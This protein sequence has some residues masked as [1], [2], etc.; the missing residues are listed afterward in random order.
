VK[1]LGK[2]VR[3]QA[4]IQ[5]IE[6]NTA[7]LWFDGLDPRKINFGLAMYGRGYTL[8]DTECNTL[9]CSFIGPSDPGECTGSPGVMSLSEIKRTAL[10]KGIKPR[11]LDDAMMKELT[12]SDQWI[13]YDDEETFAAKKRFANSLCFGGTMIWSIDFQ[14]TNHVP[15]LEASDGSVPALE[16]NDNTKDEP[17]KV[18]SIGDT[19]FT[20]F[21]SCNYVQKQSIARAW[22]DVLRL[23]EKPSQFNLDDKNWFH[24]GCKGICS[25][26]NLETGI[27]GG[28][29]KK[30][31]GD[32]EKI[33]S[34]HS[35]CFPSHILGVC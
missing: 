16:A 25:A 13:G 9:G 2:I 14:E 27:W 10:R 24:I 22:Q 32:I 34:M 1:T 35:N 8:A 5:E 11:Y 19:P 12:W 21:E 29:I 23:V 17:R 30:R 31:D 6:K 7:P 20:G 26:T 28:D 33:R 18:I 15:A 4:D 3:G